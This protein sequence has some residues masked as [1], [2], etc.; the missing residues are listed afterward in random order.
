[1]GP[2]DVPPLDVGSA[3]VH[4]SE[5]VPPPAV[6]AVASVVAQDSEVDCPTTMVVGFAARFVTAAAEGFTIRVAVELALPV[7]PVQVRV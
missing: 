2:I 1:M 6:Q 4:P 7:A 5:P 3:P